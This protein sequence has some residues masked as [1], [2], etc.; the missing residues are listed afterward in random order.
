MKAKRPPKLDLFFGL[1]FSGNKALSSGQFMLAG[2]AESQ[3]KVKNEHEKEK[4]ETEVL[5]NGWQMAKNREICWKMVEKLA[6]RWLED[7]VK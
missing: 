5:V 1:D 2:T 6:L 7:N 3:K 4:L